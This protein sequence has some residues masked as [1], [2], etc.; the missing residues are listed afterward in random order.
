MIGGW[1]KVTDV[2]IAVAEHVG[3]F[4]HRHLY[5]EIWP[6]PLVEFEAYHRARISPVHYPETP[7]PTRMVSK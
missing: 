3:W 4:N 7:V 1:K 5:G 6:V 2:E